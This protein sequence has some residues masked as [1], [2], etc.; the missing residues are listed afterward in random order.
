MPHPAGLPA[1]ECTPLPAG[2][3]EHILAAHAAY[4]AHRQEGARAVLSNCDLSGAKLRQC[5]LREA[6][7][8]GADLHGADLSAADFSGAQLYCADL[9]RIDGRLCNFTRA[10]LR[11]AKL[12][13]SNL[14]RATLDY[15]DFR[16]GR[17]M[18]QMENGR[19]QYIDRSG[20]GANVDFGQCALHGATFECAFLHGAS[21]RGAII[22]AT[23]FKDA[24]L[25]DTDFTGAVLS[26]VR[27]EELHLPDAMLKTCIIAPPV[28][29]SMVTRHKLVVMLKAHQRW[30]ESDGR[31]EQ[32]AVLDG[33]D[34][35]PLG[36]ALTQFKLTA[37]F[38]RRITGI[39]MNFTGLELQGA[40]FEDA[41]LRGAVFDGADLR[42]AK[43]RGARLA[44][45][46]FRN[47]DMR[48]LS[49]KSGERMELDLFRA[50]VTD[51]QLAEAKRR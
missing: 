29:D 36:R 16:P 25:S 40:N 44:Q 7:L 15:A 31:E 51:E 26:E 6:E 39:A 27:L 9:Q 43:F 11:G 35:R 4:L 46:R 41:D 37:V 30:I 19:P 10:D 24:R 33:A 21:F 42:G 28:Q 50:E 18:R 2:A 32:P 48:S 13:G 1:S 38:A 5:V 23:K 22:H 8:T 3:L 20:S 12:N 14:T 49:L 47:A 34:L 17:L 45:A